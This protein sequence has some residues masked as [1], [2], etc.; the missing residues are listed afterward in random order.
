MKRFYVVLFSVLCLSVVLL[1]FSFAKESGTIDTSFLHE[2]K[3]SEYRIVYSNGNI[4]NT[5]NN[6][7][8]L[9]SFTNKKNES[10]D[11]YIKLEEKNKLEYKNVF[12]KIND[13]TEHLL[14]DDLIK[15]GS[16]D[17][18][19]YDGDNQV[20]KLDVY[21]KDDAKYNFVIKIANSE[22]KKSINNIVNAIKKDNSVYTD[23]KGNIRY[24]G[25]SANNYILYNG[26][27]HRII[28]VVGDK[29]KIISEIQGLGVYDTSKGEYATLEDYLCTYNNSEV[30][31]TNVLQYKSWINDR[32]FWLKDTDGNKAYYGSASNGLGL[33]NKNV[34][35]YLRYVYYLDGK[36]LV[37]S[38]NGTSS[39][40]Y[41]VSYGS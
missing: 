3:A 26:K 34:D 25:E 21:T 19:G 37:V 38:G 32:G 28:G 5:V 6:K 40:P 18:Y 7:S 2:E 13:G 16:F 4:L 10:T 11:I 31:T 8:T 35:F 15:L 36:S 1:G 39:K 29:V 22:E 24:Y 33:Y 27:V 14:V 20:Y 17:A 12:Y 9:I 23:K 30:N 41:E